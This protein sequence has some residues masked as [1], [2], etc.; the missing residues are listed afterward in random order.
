MAVFRQ[1]LSKVPVSYSIDFQDSHLLSEASHPGEKLL[2]FQIKSFDP[3]DNLNFV[4]QLESYRKQIT[5]QPGATIKNYG[6]DRL[7]F[8]EQ[9]VVTVFLKDNEIKGFC[10][11]WHRKDYPSHTVRILNRYWFD[12]DVRKNYG[13]KVVLRLP[14]FLSIEHQCLILKN[15]GFKWVFISRPYGSEKWCSVASRILNE[16][17]SIRNWRFSN[18]LV[19]VCPQPSQSSCW[20]FIV[21]SKL[22]EEDSE[23]FL[24]RNR[25]STGEFIERFKAG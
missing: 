13:T 8:M 18:D 3:K 4:E 20:Q 1:H 22:C 7:N 6:H 12:Y 9:E 17:S 5:N 24:L 2:T 25:L 21:F 23:F 14:M 16:Q 19:L 15:K 11:A 10:T